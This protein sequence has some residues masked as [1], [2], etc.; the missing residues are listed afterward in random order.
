MRPVTFFVAALLVATPLLS[1]ASAA[2]PKRV[3]STVVL[4]ATAVKNLGLQAE[5]TEESTFET[6]VFA[7][8]RIEPIASRRA[9]VSSRVP[10]RVMDLKVA[11]GDT[12]AAGAD[13]LKLESRQP[14]DP[15]PSITLK[16]PLGGLVTECAVR[17]G[18]PVETSTALLEITDLTEVH[19]IARVPEHIAGKLKPGAEAHIRVAASPEEQLEG[20]L[21]RLGTAT[22]RESGTI[23]AIFELQSKGLPLRPGMRAEFSIVLSRRENV[24]SIPRAALQGDAAFRFVYVE[25]FG[26]KHAYVKTPVEIG[27]QND[28]RVELLGGILPG[29]KVVTTGA[30]ALAFAGQGSISLKEA[31]DAAHGHEHNEDGSELTPEQRAKKAA[32][33]S[34]VGH[35]D[36]E[37]GFDSLTAFF[38]M[39]TGVLLVL[40]MAA[41]VLRR[42]PANA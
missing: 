21:L 26:L 20:K 35:A 8:G 1:S 15:P 16:A 5:E 24:M 25:D 40:L 31:L 39:T 37:G 23:D 28:S 2:D 27:A 36:H 42:K 41:V 9:V 3:A 11:V 7:L 10:G 32:E 4:D 14:G 34:R 22:D 33:K 6:T 13:V 19:A 18:E 30:Y 29:D 17:L 12:V 38:A